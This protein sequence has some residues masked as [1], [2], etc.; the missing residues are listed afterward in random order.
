MTIIIP[1]KNIQTLP[2]VAVMPK[3]KI[4]SV[5]YTNKNLVKHTGVFGDRKKVVLI[6]ATTD[7]GTG[8]TSYEDAYNNSEKNPFYDNTTIVERN[9]GN[10]VVM[11]YFKT[12]VSFDLTSTI[13][14]F[15]TLKVSI[16]AT[17]KGYKDGV[18]YGTNSFSTV[19][20]I[21]NSNQNNIIVENYRFENQV[22]FLD[23]LVYRKIISGNIIGSIHLP[24]DYTIQLYGD[25]YNVEEDTIIT[26]GDIGDFTLENNE[27]FQADNNIGANLS[28]KIIEEYKNGKQTLKI[29]CTMGDYYDASNKKV[30]SVNSPNLLDSDNYK[31]LWNADYDSETGT[32]SQINADTKT[33]YSFQLQKYMG[34]EYLGELKIKSITESQRVGLAFTKDDSFDTIR[35]KLNGGVEDT[36]VT[37]SASN[38]ENGKQYCFSAKVNIDGGQ[39]NVYWNEMQIN[40]GA[41]ALPYDKGNLPMTFQQYDR[42]IPMVR[43]YIGSDVPM[44]Y[45]TTG[46]VMEFNVLG[47]KIYYDGAVWQELSLQEC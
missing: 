15:L 45:T 46:A 20:S 33:E 23:V 40:Y 34:D 8:T 14:N 39:G 11:Q 27:L 28:S 7:Y 37:Y 2:Q 26:S 10:G 38:L 36:G 6:I 24:I 12:T 47:V 42:V 21:I 32:I 25:Y 41:R 1:S 31:Q 9:M 18:Q 5:E 19:Q 30:I 29:L 35:F 22:L 13:Y 16:N 3:N 17:T 4:K 43:N 44:S